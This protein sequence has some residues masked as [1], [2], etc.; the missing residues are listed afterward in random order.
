MKTAFL[1]PGQGSQYI[2]MGKELANVFFEAKEVFQEVDDALN[3]KLSHLMFAG[4]LEELTST[5]N[6]QPAIMA[7]SIATLRVIL[8][9]SGKKLPDLCQFTAG[10]SLG[11]Y[12]ALCAA[13]ALSLSATA[14]LLRIRG[15]AMLNAA[16]AGKGAM[17]AL[18]GATEENAISIINEVSVHGLCQIAN[19][20]GA[21][22][23]ILSGEVIAIDKAA[24]VAS[25]FGVKKAIK[26]NVSSAFHSELMKPA[27]SAMDQALGH[28][29]FAKP[30][31]PV[32][33]N[34]TVAPYHKDF[35]KHLVEQV[36]GKVRWR[37]T[38]EFFAS[39][40]V[41]RYVEIGSGKVLSGLAKRIAPDTKI[42]STNEPVEI[43]QMILQY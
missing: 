6:A 39:Q 28:V 30:T 29:S 27:A 16:P 7:V 13:D 3:Q 32:I 18:I 26:L 12:S 40:H 43:E 1:F 11:E 8:K 20:N 25:S 22:Q 2:G 24:E 23:W 15:D 35:S 37:E 38:M 4:D 10:H 17:L 9:Q 42:F 34:V 41:E 31:V 5:Q 14:Q 21:G 36:T 19:D 33:S